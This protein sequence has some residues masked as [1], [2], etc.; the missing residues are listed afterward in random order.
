MAVPWDSV[1]QDDQF[2]SEPARPEIPA[3]ESS[4]ISV[5]V[6]LFG[7]LADAVAE[8]PITLQ[9]N[10]P[11]SV[12]EVI[13]ELGRT[14]GAGLLGRL[15]TPEGEKDRSCRVFVNGEAVTDTEVK[16]HTEAVPAQVELI[17]LSA[18]EGG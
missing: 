10:N 15:T 17:V 3:D 4:P 2:W 6:W 1:V 14:C 8:R 5:Q 7:S 9:L 12:A 13:A 18:L 11:F 16:I